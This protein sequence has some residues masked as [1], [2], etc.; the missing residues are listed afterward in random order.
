MLVAAG[1]ILK[2]SARVLYKEAMELNLIF[3]KIRRTCDEA[4]S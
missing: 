2:E 4:K 1:G 3:G